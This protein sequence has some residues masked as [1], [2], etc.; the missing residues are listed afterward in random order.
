MYN[1]K[2]YKKLLA[3]RIKNITDPVLDCSA[4][5]ENEIK[6][7]TKILE[8]YNLDNRTSFWFDTKTKEIIDTNILNKDKSVF[9]LKKLSD[10]F[11][12][13][14][15]DKIALSESIT[16]K[17]NTIEKLYESEIDK[18]EIILATQLIVDRL[19]KTIEN[20]SS[21]IY[22]EV[23]P[24]SDKIKVVFGKDT[25]N[26]WTDKVKNSLDNLVSQTIETKDVIFKVNSELEKISWS[27]QDLNDMVTYDEKEEKSKI[28]DKIDDKEKE[29]EKYSKEKNSD[30]EK[31]RELKT[32]SSEKNKNQEKKKKINE[33]LKIIIED[34]KEG[35]DFNKAVKSASIISGIK[36]N[37]L[38]KIVESINLKKKLF[39]KN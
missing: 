38:L 15:F 37:T 5:T 25:S 16:S 13:I 10:Y 26:Y 28:E 21:I 39:Q 22:E 29:E 23:I 14:G 12:N 30:S 35:F 20:L 7:V 2:N 4:L 8:D 33:A 24:I 27:G 19:Q 18:A 31:F 36:Y 1:N 11:E 34:L 6:K 9:K 3:E 32:E 17:K